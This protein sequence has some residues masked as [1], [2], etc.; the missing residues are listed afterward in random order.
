MA[1]KA[2][3]VMKHKE[4]HFCLNA[5]VV[6]SA[7]LICASCSEQRLAS[8]IPMSDDIVMPGQGI[9]SCCVGMSV[10]QLQG[11]WIPG[12]PNDFITRD[13]LYHP[14][15]GI[16]VVQ[17]D[18]MV[19]CVSC[20][21]QLDDDFLEVPYRGKT[22]QGISADSSI[23]NVIQAYGRPTCISATS[24]LDSGAEAVG[25]DYV[26]LGVYFSFRDRV[27]TAVDV[28]PPQ[29]EYDPQMHQDIGDTAQY[30]AIGKLAE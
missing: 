21:Y 11:E 17:K 2:C 16:V 14:A 13:Y 9:R 8:S 12:D 1:K 22:E 26:E 15:M 30:R 29:A 4:N 28:L 10:D 23:E 24:E 25:L 20:V 3:P 5:S 7:L 19:Y 27:L 6:L 18:S